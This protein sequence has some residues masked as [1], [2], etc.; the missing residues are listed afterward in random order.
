MHF[1]LTDRFQSSFFAWS[2]VCIA[3]IA[4]D[5]QPPLLPG[6]NPEPG[7]GT[8]AA[9]VVADCIHSSRVKEIGLSLLKKN[10]SVAEDAPSDIFQSSDRLT[11][12]EVNKF[13]HKLART[14]VVFL[15]LLHL[16]IARNRDLLLNVIQERRKE[17]SAA[18]AAAAAVPPPTKPVA[19]AQTAMTAPAFSPNPRSLMRPSSFSERDIREPLR[20][21]HTTGENRSRGHGRS[22]SYADD[23][24]YSGSLGGSAGNV[25]TDSAIAVQSELQRAFISLTKALYPGIVGIMQGECPR[26]L[27]QCCQE[28]YFSLGTYRQARIG[29]LKCSMPHATIC[30]VGL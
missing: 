5:I 21:R 16:L 24:S 11:E 25:R 3:A 7:I 13:Q 23:Q 30:F 28:N 1:I 20:T 12:D 26:W 27:K 19:R 9:K 6:I 17:S 29:K 18:A 4:S 22:K 10:A 14:I 2:I 15:E 8:H